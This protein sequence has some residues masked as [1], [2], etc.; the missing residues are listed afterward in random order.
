[1]GALSA[2]HCQASTVKKFK[3]KGKNN[4]VFIFYHQVKDNVYLNTY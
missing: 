4:F 1:M 2:S 3:N